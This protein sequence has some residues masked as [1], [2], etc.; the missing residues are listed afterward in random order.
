M[1]RPNTSPYPLLHLLSLGLLLAG[2]SPKAND[3]SASGS[4]EG[5]DESTTMDPDSNETETGEE[6]INECDV[7]T[8]D[9][10]DGE[11]CV[12]WADD[13]GNVWNA[14]R[15]APVDGNGQPGDA[16][17]LVGEL[18]GIDD[19]A[20]GS[21][22]MRLDDGTDNGVCVPQCEGTAET[23]SCE[24]I[25]RTC[26]VGN[27]GVLTVCME[28]CD[29]TVQGCPAGLG[30]YPLGP[31][32][33]GCWPDFSGDV[34]AYGDECMWSNSCD[35]G[36]L[37]WNPEAVPG[38]EGASCCSEYCNLNDPDPDAKCSGQAEG[39]VCV[40]LDLGGGPVAGLEHVGVCEVPA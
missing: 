11:K 25:G 36:L 38:C 26:I 40:P 22:C 6:H 5:T 8:Q 18:T 33:Y 3:D 17:T 7:W 16:C 13:G 39:Q 27:D 10:P 20:L 1:R 30:C 15:C 35:P 34:G 29:P 24:D 12:P 19:C 31:E 23:P 21:I 14:L 2:C 9:C 32:T 28:K 4:T 37:C